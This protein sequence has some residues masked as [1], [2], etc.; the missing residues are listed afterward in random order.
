MD[1]D[2]A[3]NQVPHRARWEVIR[4]YGVWGPLL[5]AILSLYC[6]VRDHGSLKERGGFPC[7]VREEVLPQ[8]EEFKYLGVLFMREGR[9]D[10]ELDRCIGAA[11]AVLWALNQSVMAKKELSQKAN[12]S[13]YWSS[14]VP[15]FTFS[16]ELWVVTQ[17]M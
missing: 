7:K 11:L 4:E 5:Q 3:Y 6:K 15:T 10:R 1:L 12:L 17:K 13:I 14:F 2:K 8:V 16:Y 9:G